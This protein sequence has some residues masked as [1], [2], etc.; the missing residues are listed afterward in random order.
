MY[1]YYWDARNQLVII[2][3]I[4]ANKAFA[5]FRYDAM[6][7][8]QT[9]TINGETT[10]YVY[11]GATGFYYYRARYYSPLYQRF[12]SEDPIGLMGGIN[13]YAYVEGE[14][15]L[16][17]DPMG[18]VCTYSQSTGVMSCRDNSGNEYARCV[19]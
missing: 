5:S 3:D 7:R 17:S 4:A 10:A 19:G 9:K 12:I 16:F 14:P 18:L 13:K 11:D 15:V 8:R 6:G 2:H 1:K